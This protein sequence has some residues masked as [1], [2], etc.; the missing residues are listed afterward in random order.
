MSAKIWGLVSHLHPQICLLKFYRVSLRIRGGD[1]SILS[2]LT[3]T[4]QM[5]WFEGQPLAPGCHAV[6]AEAGNSTF[7]LTCRLVGKVSWLSVSC[8]DRRWRIGRQKSVSG[9]LSSYTLWRY[10]FCESGWNL[11]TKPFLSWIFILIVGSP[12]VSAQKAN[13]R[14]FTKARN[15][16]KSKNTDLMKRTKVLILY[17]ETQALE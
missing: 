13:L 7:A 4:E 12:K 15:G 1:F 17:L 6:Y 2:S 11:L 9:P 3:Y 16:I 10:A 14:E 8:L 5:P